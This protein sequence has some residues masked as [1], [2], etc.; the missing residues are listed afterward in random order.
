[1]AAGPVTADTPATDYRFGVAETQRHTYTVP[2]T[3]LVDGSNVLAV[4]LHQA[5]GSPDVSFDL[6]LRS[7]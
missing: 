1:V 7:A 5:W 4:S 3:A 6:R 2:A